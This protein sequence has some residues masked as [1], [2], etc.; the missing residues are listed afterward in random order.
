[1]EGKINLSKRFL[2][3]WIKLGL[4]LLLGVAGC[5]LPIPF[6]GGPQATL[7]TGLTLPIGSLWKAPVSTNGSLDWESASPAAV[8]QH[9]GYLLARQSITG[10]TFADKEYSEGNQQDDIQMNMRKMVETDRVVAVVGTSTNTST[11][12][13]ASLVNFFSLPMIIPS[14][15]GD[16]LLPSNNL[17]AF[18]LSAPGSAYASYLFG[19]LIK[20]P[21]AASPSGAAA[22]TPAAN[23]AAQ[24]GIRLAIIYEANTFG[25]SAA[26]AT[27]HAAMKQ[28]MNI[29]TYS[30]FAADNPD[31]TKINDLA[32][33]AKTGQA[34]IVYL[35]SSDPGVAKMLAGAFKNQTGYAP[36]LIGQAGGFANQAF[37]TSP[38]AEGVYVLRQELNRSSCPADINST[39]QAQN[40]AAINLLD[41]AVQE[42][43]KSFA[44]PWWNLFPA[45]NLDATQLPLMREKVRDALKTFNADLP[46]MGKV[47]FD[48]TGQN[49]LLK[50]EL[51]T[52]RSGMVNVVPV[53]V[54]QQAL[55]QVSPN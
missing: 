50:F 43:G 45:Q 19:T 33:A 29:V 7:L 41:Q 49:K 30:S 1:L 13:A 26:V 18:R 47:A 3:N 9:T 11:M 48:N 34:Q 8:E 44:K 22:P 21:P 25:E 38:Q 12:R 54:F 20:T 35:V 32:D 27:A 6:L 10:T 4:V 31:V 36:L 14:A 2:N 52:I 17:W 37:L 16:N 46:C 40:F 5:S 55:P 23:A 28:A 42:A 51:V 24:Q 53:G 39:D 15:V